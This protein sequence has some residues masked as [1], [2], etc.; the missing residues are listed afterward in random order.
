[1]M[2]VLKSQNVKTGI[3]DIID[4]ENRLMSPLPIHS[5]TQLNTQI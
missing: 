3:I 2:V 4:Q 5:T 1:M